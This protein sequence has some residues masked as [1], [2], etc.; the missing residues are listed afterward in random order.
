[1]LEAAL[2]RR[3][4]PRNDPTTIIAN[5]KVDGELLNE[6]DLGRTMWTVTVGG[7]NT[8]TGLTAFA[9]RYL[10]THPKL[11]QQLIEHPELYPEATEE[12]LRISTV[13][14]TS[15]RTVTRDIEVDGHLLK[16]GD[17]VFINRLSANRDDLVFE[18]AEEVVLDRTEN[19]HMAFGLGPHRCIGSNVA[20]LMFQIVLHEVLTRI[21]KVE[22]DESRIVFYEGSPNISGT[23]AMPC[24]FP[25]GP[26]LNAPSP[27]E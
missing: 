22:V 11:R 7:L 4:H 2:D 23:L 20:R 19:R 13:A 10:S 14:R 12:F 24:R 5:L 9:V 16:R 15:T 27:L 1:M 25:P 26:K 3:D 21:P 17:H 18:E 8:T 6:Y